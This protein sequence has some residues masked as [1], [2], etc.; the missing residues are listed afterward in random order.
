MTTVI[1]TAHC[2]PEKT[3][4]KVQV[5]GGQTTYIEDGEIQGFSIYGGREIAVSEVPKESP[6]GGV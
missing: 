3:K 2:D 4:V 6:T 5:L 1:V